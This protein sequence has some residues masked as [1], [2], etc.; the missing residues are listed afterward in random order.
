LVTWSIVDQVDN[1][2]FTIERSEDGRDFHVLGRAAA[3]EAITYTYTD[4]APLAGNSFYRVRQTDFDG[5]FSFSPV[6]NS[7]RAYPEVRLYPNLAKAGEMVTLELPEALQQGSVDISL[8]DQNGRE[9][10]HKRTSGEA[11][12]PL[13]TKDLPEGMYLVNLR[14]DRVNW[15]GRLVIVR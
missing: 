2:Y 5:Q 4:R 9:I 1:D 10:W 12:Q 6:V 7:R 14:N 8:F 15:T 13:Q 11:V 3:T